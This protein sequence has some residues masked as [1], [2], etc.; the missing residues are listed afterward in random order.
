MQWSTYYVFDF[1][2]YIPCP[3]AAQF[4]QPDVTNVDGQGNNSDL[5]ADEENSYTNYRPQ[6]SEGFQNNISTVYKICDSLNS[7]TS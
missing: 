1:I 5:N 2:F 7:S 3:T 6:S 4:I